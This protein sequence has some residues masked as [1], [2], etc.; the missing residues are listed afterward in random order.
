VIRG[1]NH[2]ANKDCGCGYLF[3]FGTEIWRNQ[4]SLLLLKIKQQRGI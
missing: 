2:D 1:L 3:H 4:P